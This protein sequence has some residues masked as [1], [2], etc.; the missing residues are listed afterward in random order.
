M[1]FSVWGRQYLSLEKPDGDYCKRAINNRPLS[2]VN[3]FAFEWI[4]YP[5]TITWS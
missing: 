1:K 4:I 3:I 5:G 2:W